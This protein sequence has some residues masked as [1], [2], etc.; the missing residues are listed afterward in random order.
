MHGGYSAGTGQAH[1]E[2]LCQTLRLKLSIRVPDGGQVG[3]KPGARLIQDKLSNR[4]ISTQMLPS[5]P[6]GL[7]GNAGLPVLGWLGSRLWAGLGCSRMSRINS[8]R[9]IGAGRMSRVIGLAGLG[10]AGLGWAGLAGWLG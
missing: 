9:V 5:W 10:W 8:R 1:D 7:A 2:V 3:C 4:N 6:A